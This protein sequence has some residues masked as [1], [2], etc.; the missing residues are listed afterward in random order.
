MGDGFGD[1]YIGYYIESSVGVVSSCEDV[2]Q[3]ALLFEQK[4]AL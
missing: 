3:T 1:N 4:D 2:L